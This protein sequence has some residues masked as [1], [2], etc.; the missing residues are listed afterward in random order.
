MRH[1]AEKGIRVTE[2]DAIDVADEIE[3]VRETAEEASVRETAETE[4]A[5]T[6]SAQET[7]ERKGE[8]ETEGHSTDDAKERD[9]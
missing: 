1:L 9:D 5:E 3:S 4:S 7:N 2:R 6:E 8:T